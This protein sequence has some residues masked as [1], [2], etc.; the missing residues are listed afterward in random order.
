MAS[1]DA[2]QA[3]GRGAGLPVLGLNVHLEAVSAGGPVPTLFTHKE[4]LSSVLEGFMQLK[5]CSR[6]EAFGAGGTLQVRGAGKFMARP[7]ALQP[8]LLPQ[9][10][11]GLEGKLPGTRTVAYSLLSL[12][13]C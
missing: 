8:S 2:S 3:A 1:P 9:P 12:E 4:L 10:L 6:Q 13:Q 5:L 7:H 11:W